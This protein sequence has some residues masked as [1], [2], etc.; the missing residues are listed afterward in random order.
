VHRT[1]A[2]AALLLAAACGV[3][4]TPPEYN[5]HSQAGEAERTEALHEV[6]ARV[7]AF[8]EALARGDAPAAAGSLAPA[9]DAVVLGM[10]PLAEAGIGEG[11]VLAAIESI[12]GTED[13]R[14]PDLRV[15]VNAREKVGWFGTHLELRPDSTAARRRVRMSGVFERGEE[16]GW[17]LVQL[18][19]SPA[20][21]PPPTAPRDSAPSRPDSAPNP[22]PAGG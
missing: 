4:R 16:G 15:R 2:A 1:L 6:E 9:P 10:D 11:A 8:R 12:D 18:H 14:T 5:S 22:S 7:A 19:L 3:E 20:N 13:A 17:R 21:A